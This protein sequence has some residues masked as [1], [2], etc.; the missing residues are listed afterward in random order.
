MRAIILA[1]VLSG[2]AHTVAV[3]APVERAGTIDYEVVSD[4]PDYV[5]PSTGDAVPLLSDEI[6][7]FDGVLLS[8]SKA[9]GAAKLRIAY[10]ELYQLSE[11]NNSTCEITADILRQGI[12]DADAE[13]QSRDEILRKLRDSWWE[14]HKLTVG[15][16]TGVFLGASGSFFAATLWGKV[17]D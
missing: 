12:A 1:I 16:I 15:I 4:L 7:P 6:A 8:E 17:G 5:G 14:K 9:I 13:I 3:D 10:D 2:C 11:I